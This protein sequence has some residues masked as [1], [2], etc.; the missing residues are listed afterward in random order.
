[1]IKSSD[2]E[3]CGESLPQTSQQFEVPKDTGSSEKK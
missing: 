3:R 2:I 1:M